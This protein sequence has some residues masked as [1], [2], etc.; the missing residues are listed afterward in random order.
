MQ[1]DICKLQD[2]RNHIG[3]ALRL[4]GCH[5]H[6][7]EWPCCCRICM[8]TPSR[9]HG[10]PFIFKNALL[11]LILVLIGT[12]AS[13]QFAFA[14]DPLTDHPVGARAGKSAPSEKL[15]ERRPFDEVVL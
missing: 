3:D 9:G 4:L 7:S 11:A 1:T 12:T 13:V 8:P 2:Q 10:T 15:L 6:C 5:G 14:Q